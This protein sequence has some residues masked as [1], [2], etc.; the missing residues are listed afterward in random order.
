MKLWKI[1][2]EITN[3]QG[4]FVVHPAVLTNNSEIDFADRFWELDFMSD[5]ENGETIDKSELSYTEKN[6]VENLKNANLLKVANGQ[7]CLTD[8]GSEW[9]AAWK[10]AKHDVLKDMSTGRGG[11]IGGMG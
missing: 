2:E 11:P 1:N 7:F 3:V 8:L 6:R 9:L 5:V 10:D 4:S